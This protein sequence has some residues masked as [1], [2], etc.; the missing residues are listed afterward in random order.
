MWYATASMNYQE[1]Q[2]IGQKMG[3]EE[4]WRYIPLLFFSR[5]IQSKKALGGK[6]EEQEKTFLYGNDEIS[7]EKLGALTARMPTEM[8]FIFKTLLIVGSHHSRAG[9][10][11]RKKL[12]NFTNKVVAEKAKNSYFYYWYLQLKLW[13][14]LFFFEYTPFWVFNSVCGG[15]V[16]MESDS[17]N[18]VHWNSDNKTPD[19]CA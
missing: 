13:L 18:E 2:N 7:F 19:F 11:T 8:T 1:M 9:G 5:T 10:S 14:R 12:L 17:K 6:M 3:L 4:Y 15:W 16:E